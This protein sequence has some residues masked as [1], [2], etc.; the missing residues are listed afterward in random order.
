MLT[1]LLLGL[2]PG[3][4][5][6][7]KMADVQHLA[8]SIL[9][10]PTRFGKKA[11]AIRTQR[12]IAASEL[13]NARQDGF[14]ICEAGNDGYA[15]ISADERMTPVLGFSQSRGFDTY[16]GTT[17]FLHLTIFLPDYRNCWMATLMN[18]NP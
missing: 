8:D 5:Q 4:A 10:R 9:N 13:T 11:K 18:I 7:R 14:Y 16:I 12:V 6:Q 17:S 2:V 1:C 3:M 15:I